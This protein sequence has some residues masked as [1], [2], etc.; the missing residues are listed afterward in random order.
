MYHISQNVPSSTAEERNVDH[1]S[2]MTHLSLECKQIQRV[3]SEFFVVRTN[4]RRQDN[5]N[6][7]YNIVDLFYSN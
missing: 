7:Y 1:A 4:N 5:M 2:F 6:I 3:A